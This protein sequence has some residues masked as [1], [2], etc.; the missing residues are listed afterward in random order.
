MTMRQYRI[1]IIIAAIFLGVVV[2]MGYHALPNAPKTV[3]EINANP[4]LLNGLRFSKGSLKG[5]VLRNAHIR[6]MVFN[7]IQAPESIIENV[8]FENC[9]F[10]KTNFRWSYFENVAFINCTMLNDGDPEDINNTTIFEYSRMNNILFDNTK[11]RHVIIHGID[12][13]GGYFLLR[14][15]NDV[16]PRGGTG[17]IIIACDLHCRIDNSNFPTSGVIVEGDEKKNSIYVQNSRLNNLFLKSTNIYIYNSILSSGSLMS[18]NDAVIKDSTITHTALAVVR[19]GYFVNNAYP[20]HGAPQEDLYAK[21]FMRYG[22][23]EIAADI[24]GH[25]YV[26]GSAGEPCHLGFFTGNVTIQN[27][28]LKQP[29]FW[30]GN[31][32]N[33]NTII[34]MKNV[35]LQGGVFTGLRVK[36]GMWENV[37]IEPTVLINDASITNVKAYRLEFTKG[38]P[39]RK[40][41]S[42]TFDVQ[43]CY[44]PFEWEE[45][46]VPTPEEMG[47]TWWPERDPGYHPDA[48]R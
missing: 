45:I 26:L 17:Q 31:K 5:L 18:D 48:A 21:G 42:F 27:I 10:T 35:T 25:A 13:N 39:W 22:L 4:Q 3:A 9:V 44:Q 24:G 40:E 11:M 47:L 2:M 20:T 37:S 23:S 8:T 36:G 14:N 29:L 34:N 41:G 19:K 15:M 33:P 32:E 16:V 46:H 6:G 30:L 1:A 43:T 28:M 7:D 12:G 38:E